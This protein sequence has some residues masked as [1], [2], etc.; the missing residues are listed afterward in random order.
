VA[1]AAAVVVVAAA[2]MAAVM[3]SSDNEDMLQ[4]ISFT[5]STTFALS[6]RATNALYML[7]YLERIY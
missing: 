6:N 7:L 3:T 4:N 5:D 1:T 2:V